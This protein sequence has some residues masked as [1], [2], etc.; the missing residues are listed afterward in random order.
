MSYS[1][2]S[3]VYGESFKTP[4]IYN[5]LEGVN[6]KDNFGDGDGDEIKELDYQYQSNNSFNSFNSMKKDVNL[7]K[8]SVNN[9]RLIDVKENQYVYPYSSKNDL[10]YSLEEE[11]TCY[12]YMNHIQRCELCKKLVYEQLDLKKVKETNIISQ[13]KD[14]LLVIIVLFVLWII[15]I[16]K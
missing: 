11:V 6:N 10:A 16:K 14:L 12:K 5:Y 15:F 9:N 13:F 2:V 4:S 7:N 1:L 8:K 3:D